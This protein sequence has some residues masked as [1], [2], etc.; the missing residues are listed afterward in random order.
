[1]TESE[2]FKEK[3][4]RP[5]PTMMKVA[6]ATKNL[7][8]KNEKMTIPEMRVWL[9]GAFEDYSAYKDQ[10]LL[11]YNFFSQY[12]PRIG[13]RFSL[14]MMFNTDSEY[15]YSA[16]VSLHPPGSLYQKDPK[17]EKAIMFTNIDY[18]SPWTAQRFNETLFSFK[19]MPSNHRSVFI[20]DIKAITFQKKGIAHIEDYGWTAFPYFDSLETDDDADTLELFVNSGIYMLPIFEGQVVGDFINTMARQD[21]PYDYILNQASKEIPSLKIRDNAGVVIK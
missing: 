3:V 17:F 7:K 9:D 10:Q 13:L 8:F 6:V 18:N 15:L 14:E 11:N 19:N 21:K 5:D 20:I 2:I 12:I 16:I 4:L 1:M